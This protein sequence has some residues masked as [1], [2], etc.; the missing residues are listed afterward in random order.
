M[1]AA[2]TSPIAERVT[3]AIGSFI[4]LTSTSEFRYEGFVCCNNPHDS[5]IGLR[6]VKCLGPEDRCKNGP[7][8]LG[9]DRI[10][11]Y[12]YFRCS[13]IKESYLRPVLHQ[14]VIASVAVGSN[15][16][17]PH[18]PVLLPGSPNTLPTPSV[19][20]QSNI[21]MV[22]NLSSSIPIPSNESTARSIVVD[23]IA[24]PSPFT[25]NESGSTSAQHTIKELPSPSHS[26]AETAVKEPM[27][28][29]STEEKEPMLSDSTEENL[30]VINAETM[31]ELRMAATTSTVAERLT[32]RLGS[33]ISLTSISEIRYEGFLC[34]NNPHDSTIGLR[35]VDVNSIPA[36]VTNNESGGTS[37]QPT[38]EEQPSPSQSLAETTVI[39]E[40]MPSNST[41]EN[42]EVINA[43]TVSELRMAAATS[44]IAERLIPALGSFISLTSISEIRYEGF[45]CYNNPR[46]STIGLR[47]EPHKNHTFLVGLKFCSDF[48]MQ[49]HFAY[50][51]PATTHHGI[52][53]VDTINIGQ[54]ILPVTSFQFQ[55][56][57]SSSF[58]FW[59]IPPP[60]A[61]MMVNKFGKPNYWAGGLSYYP[62]AP[63]SLLQALYPRPILNQNVI[64]SVAVG[65]S[66]SEPHYPM[67]LPGS[68]NTLLPPFLPTP[69]VQ[70][71]S[72]ISVMSN[73]SSSIPI[74]NNGSIALSTLVDVNAILAAVTNNKSGSTSAQPRIEELPS[75]SH[76]LAETAVME[77]MPSNS[78]EENPGVI[79]VETVYVHS[80]FPQLLLCSS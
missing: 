2:A 28:S 20:F 9:S 15:F 29:D 78:A 70:L 74:P 39:M 58:I 22:S 55:S 26:L 21:S 3:P 23:V 60:P 75:P 8:V 10:F 25:N 40:P 56:P 46:D 1:A 13:N 34:Y 14:N 36:S 57:S 6:H 17:K 7:Q 66:F 27:P 62:P 43:E 31:L 35:Y 59:E 52:A 72:N 77:P 4:S 53:N 19:Q 71:Q 30:G 44:V 65:S 68:P 12:M 61:P 42:P 73:L 51:T 11:G 80:L 37:A 50:P 79:N 41:E 5:T 63:Q 67:L 45:L 49:Y 16:S 69:S 32:P 47:Y 64:T 76:S 54:P 48:I 18:H 33:F 38:I 24:T